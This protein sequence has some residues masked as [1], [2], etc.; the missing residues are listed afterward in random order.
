[1][2]FD[3]DVV[4]FDGTVYFCFCMKGQTVSTPGSK[5]SRCLEWFG[6]ARLLCTYL[7]VVLY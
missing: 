2:K 3:V 6:E 1:V 5:I 4:L 7:R